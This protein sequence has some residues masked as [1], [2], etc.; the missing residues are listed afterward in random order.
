MKGSRA[1]ESSL[2]QVLRL[3]KMLHGPSAAI[4]IVVLS[5]ALAIA[6]KVGLFGWPLGFILLSWLFKY[7]FATLDELASGAKEA[8][9]LSVEMVMHSVGEWRTLLPLIL[10]VIA[11]VL[12]GA[13]SFFF[14]PVPGSLLGIVV[15]IGLPAVLAVQG[16][17]GGAR[18]SLNPY[19]CV[20]MAQ[21]LGGGY[22]WIVGVT[23][24][25]AAVCLVALNTPTPA[26]LRFGLLIYTWLALIVLT[27]GMLFERRAQ[28]EQ[29]TDFLG[30]QRELPERDPVAERRK[31][32]IDTI[33]AHWR[34]GSMN[35]AWHAVC[36]HLD[37]SEDQLA[38]L[39]FLFMR[40]LTWQPPKFTQRV[41]Q[42]LVS[43]LL[44][45]NREGEA[46]V[47]TRGQLKAD[48]KFRPLASSELIRLA[49]IAKDNTDTATA[50][51]LLR[52]F[53]TFYPSES[54]PPGLAD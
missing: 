42:E 25:L 10:V 17:T 4:T 32:A 5:V 26:F 39:R 51:E 30:E 13:N 7:S 37:A 29:Q 50:H 2:Q 54:L 46:L 53:A 15:L 3:L 33:Y 47:V 31:E 48:A 24:V 11:F 43:R 28:I 19:I 22:A 18:Q 35:D 49:R 16:W 36:R 23:A 45:A 6:S 40:T 21:A 38:E 9:V 44:A 41:A 52:D 20:K 8:P 27:G 14:G 34:S 12:T 1:S